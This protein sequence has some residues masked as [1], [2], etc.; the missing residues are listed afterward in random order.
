MH[1]DVVELNALEAVTTNGGNHEVLMM[2]WPVP[3]DH[4]L[5]AAKLWGPNTPIVFIGEV[6]DHSLG[7]AGLGGCASDE[8]FNQTREEFVF[9]SYKGRSMLDRATVRFLRA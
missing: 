7:F 2:S 9:N 8:F 6:T 4:A 3:P 5:A 1:C